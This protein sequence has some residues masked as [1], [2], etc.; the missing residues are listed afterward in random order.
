MKYLEWTNDLLVPGRGRKCG[1]CA[2][3]SHPATVY[4]TPGMRSPNAG[5]G[6][7]EVRQ[8]FLCR[9]SVKSF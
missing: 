4:R 7:K 6:F 8:V 5:I 9:V 1:L 3:L 2:H